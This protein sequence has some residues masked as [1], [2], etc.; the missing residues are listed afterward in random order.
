MK[1][2]TMYQAILREGREEGREEE[3]ELIAQNML[4]IGLTPE[5]VV[6]VTG[7]SGERVQQLHQK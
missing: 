3:K 7:L 6:R 1:E 5:Q 2:S 4:K